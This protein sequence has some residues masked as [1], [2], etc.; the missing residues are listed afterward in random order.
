[1]N[2]QLVMTL[3]LDE[4]LRRF[5]LHLTSGQLRWRIQTSVS[6][7]TGGSTFLPL[8]LSV[9]RLGTTDRARPPGAKDSS[10][11]S[12]CPVRCR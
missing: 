1:M 6:W 12:F 10:D 2:E 8:L 5:L 7:P 9:A 4:F 3:S 11:L